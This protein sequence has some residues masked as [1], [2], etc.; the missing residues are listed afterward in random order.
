METD[1]HAWRDIPGTLDEISD[2]G[3]IR[4]KKTGKALHTWMGGHGDYD[5]VILS[6]N[7]KERNITVSRLMAYAFRLI[8]SLDAKLDIDHI[9]GNR[10]NNVLSNLQAISHRENMRKI[11]TGP[12]VMIPVDAYLVGSDK[13][14]R[15]YECIS[16]A[17]RDLHVSYGYV[18]QIVAK[19]PHRFSIHGYTFRRHGEEL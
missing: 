14:F 6:I 7:G 8:D 2:H 15:S 18:Q 1:N 17:T 4:R 10:H 13:I 9:D 11:K 5:K 12:K 19:K 3:E 16:D